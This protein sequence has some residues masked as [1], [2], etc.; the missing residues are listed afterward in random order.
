MLSKLRNRKFNPTGIGNEGDELV[1]VCY[2][3]LLNLLLKN[4]M[5]A[6]PHILSFT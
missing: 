1:A 6:K 4:K 2:I 5:F 3:E